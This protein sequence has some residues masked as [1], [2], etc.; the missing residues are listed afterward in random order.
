M[1][2][3]LCFSLKLLSVN[4]NDNGQLTNDKSDTTELVL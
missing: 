2:D 4:D 3:W 1:Q